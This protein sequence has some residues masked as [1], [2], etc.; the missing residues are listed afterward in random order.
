MNLE[1]LDKMTPEERMEALLK[2]FEDAGIE[3]I[4][5]N[6]PEDF[7]KVAQRIEEEVKE[8]KKGFFNWF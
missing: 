5:V 6:H 2:K 4:E 7:K 8:E 3:V 1:E